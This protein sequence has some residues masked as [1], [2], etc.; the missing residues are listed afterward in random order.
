MLNG[1]RQFSMGLPHFSMLCNSFYFNLSKDL[2]RAR[3]LGRLELV[4]HPKLE[5]TMLPRPIECGAH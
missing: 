5:G 4:F 3:S 1:G 2:C